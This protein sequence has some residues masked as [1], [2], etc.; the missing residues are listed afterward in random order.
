MTQGWRK[1]AQGSLRHTVEHT[2]IRHTNS[3]LFG[4]RAAIQLQ[5]TRM[6]VLH[7]L[8]DGTDSGRLLFW[9]ERPQ[10]IN[11]LSYLR[12]PTRHP[13]ARGHA[14][15]VRAAGKYM[16][17]SLAT[18]AKRSHRALLLPTLEG[19]PLPSPELA[20]TSHDTSTLRWQPWMIPTLTLTDPALAMKRLA[21]AKLTGNLTLGASTRFWLQ[22]SAFVDE[23][24][25][26]R[27][28]APYAGDD[29]M[30]LLAR[31]SPVFDANASAQ[32][33]ALAA[34]MPG[35]CRAIVPD[36]RVYAPIDHSTPDALPL[37]AQYIERLLDSR[38]RRIYRPVLSPIASAE[39]SSAASW[40]RKLIGRSKNAWLVVR[41]VDDHVFGE[42]LRS[43]LAPFHVLPEARGRLCVQLDEPELHIEG[44]H[45]HL[46]Y[47]IQDVDE[48]SVLIPVRHIWHTHGRDAVIAQRRFIDAHQ[49]LLADL[50]RAAAVSALIADT[51][52]EPTPTGAVLTVEQA[53]TF[54]KEQANALE[55]AGIGVRVPAWW[56]QRKVTLQVSLPDPDRVAFFG[57]DTLLKFNWQAALGDMV[58]TRAEFETLS[59][60]K[61]P[62]AQVR[63]QWVEVNA[64]NLRRALRF[65]DRKKDGLTLAEAVQVAAD[66]AEH[67]LGLNVSKVD[68][69]G[70]VRELLERLRGFRRISNIKPAESF[71]GTLRPYQ[72]RG[73]SWL[74]Y[75]SDFGLGAC[76]ADDMGLG[77]CVLPETHVLVGGGPKPIEQLWNENAG[78]LRFD[79]EGTWATP[80]RALT[81]HSLDQATG[82][83]VTAQVQALY[84]QYIC[85][86]VR[87]ITLENGEMIDVTRRHRLLTQGGWTN[88][89]HAGDRVCVPANPS[90]AGT[91][92]DPDSVS[93]WAQHSA[94][95]GEQAECSA[96]DRTHPGKATF[97]DLSQ[98]DQ[99]CYSRR[100]GPH[101]R[102][103]H[104]IDRKHRPAGMGLNEVS[105]RRTDGRVDECGQSDGD[106]LVGN[107]GWISQ[108]GGSG[109]QRDP[110][111]A[112]AGTLLDAPDQ[113]Q[114]RQKRELNYCRIKTIEDMPYAGWVYDLA[115][116]RHHNFVANNVLCHNTVQLLAVVEHWR[117]TDKP[118]GPVLLV[119]PMSIVGNWQREAAR[120]APKLKVLVHHGIGR[121]RDDAFRTAVK[122]HDLVLTT[123][124]L[125]H[126]D[127]NTLRD[128]DWR[129]VVLDE[130]QNIKNHD[131]KQ[132]RAVRALP[133]RQRIALTGTPVENRL[134]E[135]WSIMDFLNPGFLGSR[136]S[137]QT[138][139]ARDVEQGNVEKAKALRR[140]MQPFLLRRL[141]TDK[142]IIEDLP[143]KVE[144]TVYCNLTREQATL[145]QAV[146]RNMLDRIADAAGIER[147][148]LVLSALMKLKQICNHPAHYLGDGSRLSGRSGKLARLE[149]MLEEAL[150]AGDKALV[151]TQYTAMAGPLTRYLAQR[152]ERE[153]LYLHGGV[154]Q[155]KRDEIVWRFQEAQSGP[156]I[157]VLSLKAGGTG[158]NLTAANHVFHFDRW[159]NPAV[160]NQA[161]D[162][163]YR[164]GQKRNVQ[165]HKLI[166]LGTLEERI[167]QLLQ[168]KRALADAIIQDGEAWMTDLS[169]QQLRDLFT[170]G[171]EAV[172]AVE[173]HG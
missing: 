93:F 28:F 104:G 114:A 49:V 84:R 61:T 76:L 13:G 65:F 60:L 99:S 50:S 158:L 79:G 12:T 20:A 15:L 108:M 146:T 5:F 2:A 19:L 39:R 172:S 109:A 118:P 119:C 144:H 1:H 48:P 142:T 23:L 148:R 138:R 70:R 120:F 111:A 154:S 37:L 82:Q 29:D 38:V 147:A 87:R 151:F 96:P 3:A 143:E 106:I 56:A 36:I 140:L 132:A 105:S 123:Y 78:N 125:A 83:I 161:T 7:T 127:V 173:S 74:A 54:L 112:H 117:A 34:A 167:D 81:V 63:G 141:K 98:P 16:G 116:A 97:D 149:A 86:M 46:S 129:A 92:Q 155:R 22:V 156:P 166:C 157:F 163:A 55:Q 77:K 128:V 41:T 17:A 164:I 47:F 169:T 107:L 139:Y 67:E 160:E 103:G 21:R 35:V 4:G 88:D 89:L 124:Q 57:V 75:L 43:W 66:G 162:R 24:I 9:I 33:R 27:A 18:R 133:A 150:S 135:L 62:L 68:A 51:L 8:W 42:T 136:E 115:I 113:A 90:H 168:K 100:S 159:W 44:S 40:L 10:R 137:F 131:S 126:R 31:W 6:A 59:R 91:P 73:L 102:H 58:L 11:S 69:K 122:Q 94:A 30:T 85:E 101:T 64:D 152:F 26:R 145:Y 121:V 153:V 45:W 165:V 72:E 80:V 110:A 171:A 32:M 95:G 170:L 14:A 130:A 53:H 134:S 25:E 71:V 52:R